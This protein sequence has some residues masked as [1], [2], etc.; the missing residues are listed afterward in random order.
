[1]R[2]LR[3][4]SVIFAFVV[5]CGLGLQAQTTELTHPAGTTASRTS[6]STSGTFGETID[7]PVADPKA[8]VKIG[9]AR[10]TILTPQLIRME[11][12]ADGKFE[13]H[14]SFVFSIDGCRCRSFADRARQGQESCAAADH[15]NTDALTLIYPPTGDGRFTR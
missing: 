8:V 4:C 12:S 1:M 11:W 5:G 10:F 3:R 7:D 6:A 14:A 15:L 2:N 9:N 13:D